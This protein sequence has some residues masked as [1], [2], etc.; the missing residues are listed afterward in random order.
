MLLVESEGCLRLRNWVLIS[1]SRV[2]V[3]VHY[4]TDILGGVVVGILCALIAILI[5]K[6]FENRIKAKK[7]LV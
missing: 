3:G 5:V 4:P 6:F 7:E 1:F 2:Y